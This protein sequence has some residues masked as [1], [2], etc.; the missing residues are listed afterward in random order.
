VG[1]AQG[2]SARLVF[3]LHTLLLAGCQAAPSPCLPPWQPTPRAPCAILEDA[4]M[5]LLHS[6][7][8]LTCRPT[9]ASHWWQDLPHILGGRDLQAGGTWMALS[10]TGRAAFLTNFRQARW[11]GKIGSL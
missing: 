6:R 3:L 11:A 9:R 5:H 4:Q 8:T 2:R 1:R 7:P 10:T